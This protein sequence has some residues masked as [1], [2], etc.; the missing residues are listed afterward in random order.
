MQMLE[1]VHVTEISYKVS[2]GNVIMN[3]L[4]WQWFALFRLAAHVPV[5]ESRF[6]SFLAQAGRGG[7]S[8]SDGDSQ[9]PS[10]RCHRN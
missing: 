6:L 1:V 2:G 9:R 10:H 4:S 3:L 7:G 8:M 5:A